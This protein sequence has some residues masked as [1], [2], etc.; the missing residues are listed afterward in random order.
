MDVDRQANPPQERM[1]QRQSLSSNYRSCSQYRK[2]SVGI[3]VDSLSKTDTKDLKEPV[4]QTAENEAYSKANCVKDCEGHTPLVEKHI[5]VEQKDTSPWVS[6]RSCNRKRS[7]VAVQDTEHTPSFPAISRRRPRSKLLEKASASHSHKFFA[8]KSGLESD[9]CRKKIS[10]NDIFSVEAGKA[11]DAE[12]VQNL[13]FSTEAGVQ[14]EKEHLEDKDRKIET[15]GRETLRVKLWEILGNVSSPNKHCPSPKCE[16]LHPDQERDEK[17]TPIEKKNLSSDTIE[18]DSQTHVLTKPVTRSLTR[19]K[20]STKKQSNKTEATKSIRRKDCPQ[21]S[22]FSFRGDWPGRLYDNFDDD[23]LPSK[24]NKTG[25][26]SSE[27]E[28]CQGRKYGNA[29]ERLQS[30]KS[31]ST[32]TVENSTVQRNKASNVSSFTAKRDDVLL[33]P[34][35]VAKNNTSLPPLNVM[36]DQ[37]DVQQSMHEVSTKNQQEYLPNSPLNSKMNFGHDPSDPPSKCKSH[38]CLPKSKHGKLQEQSPADK[39]FNRTDIRSFKSLLSSKSAECLPDVQLE[40][41]DSRCEPNDSPNNSFLVKPSSQSDEDGENR[42]SKSSTDETDSE[43]SED[44]PLV[45]DCRESEEL[46]PEI[47]THENFPHSQNKSLGNDKDVEMTGRTPE[48]NSLKDGIQD[49]AELE[50]YLEQNQEDGLARAV[51]LFAVALNRLK[52][53]LKSISSRRSADILRAAVEEIFLK[54]QN[55]ESAIQT[56]MGKLTNQNHLKRKQLETRFQEQQVQ[57]LGI[58]KRFKEEVNQHLQDYDSLI[59]DLEEHEI[60]LKRS[61]ESQRSAHKKVLAR[62]EQEINV[63]LDGAESRIM[64]VQELA[65]EKM[66][67]LKVGIAECLKHGAFG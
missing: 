38:G 46:S 54:L 65:R 11:N 28:T 53:K 10:G 9:E 27:T 2:V 42:T 7:S 31:R 24:G 13:A 22:I 16:E 52:T 21:K 60:E 8:A 49:N 59:E 30:G 55:A 17:Q 45:Q 40:A 43:R 37:K 26:M 34:K 36:T 50:M 56:D 57:L 3:L 44:E 6:T 15:G 14:L 35:G 1:S 47:F 51:A 32:P 12:H 41:S 5:A 23:Y 67:Q 61:M 18:S 63:Q 29:E 64:A 58:S 48:S 20:A 39:I 25:R 19:K 4:M 66:H 33:E 62:V